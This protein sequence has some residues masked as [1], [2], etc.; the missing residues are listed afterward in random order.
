MTI[1][2]ADFSHFKPQPS[3]HMA[4]TPQQPPAILF[5]R[6]Y[7]PRLGISKKCFKFAATNQ[8]CPNGGMVD[9]RDLKS[10]GHCGCAGS[11]PASSTEKELSAKI[12]GD[13][14]FCVPRDQGVMGNP[15]VMGKLDQLD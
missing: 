14:F 10:L 11:S 1:F 4:L 9:T 13:S 5:Y 12:A 7:R 8:G 3:L 15:G 2:S 6:F